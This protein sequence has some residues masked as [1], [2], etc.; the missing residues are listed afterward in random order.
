MSVSDVPELF[1]NAPPVRLQRKLGLID[2]RTRSIGKRALI[3]VLVGWLPLNL[4][5]LL[6]AYSGSQGVIS[7]LWWEIGVHA[8]YLVAAPLLVFAENACAPRLN[9]II[10][11]FA[12]SGIVQERDRHRFTEA[13]A[14]TRA[15]V[16]SVA[17]EIVVIACAYVVTASALYA[18]DYGQIPLWYK[19]DGG[20]AV[21]S[22]AGWWHSLVSLPLLLALIFGWIWRLVLWSRLL[23]L[24]ARLKLRLVASHPDHAAGLGFVGQSLEAFSVVGLAM[25]TI[26]A[27]RSA[28]IVLTTGSV[29]TPNLFANIGILIA[30]LVLFAAPLLI[31][32]PLLLRTWQRGTLDYGALAE[33][34]GIAFERKWIT[35]AEIK[36]SALQ[37]P[38]FSATTDLY[39]IA[40]NVT[41]MRLIPVDSKDLIALCTAMLIPFVPVVLLAVPADTIIE[42]LKKLLL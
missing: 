10:H 41:A 13:I 38:D 8:R 31:F 25:T 27:G 15:L 18:H 40:A 1:E 9:R 37:Q 33:H 39:S 19:S 30:L 26:A 5:A 29:P 24:I 3:I 7:S 32:T 16:D 42:T 2:A 12:D 4:L 34:V 11:E 23:W 14:S 22:P 20:A 21:F 35:K 6:Q 17:A 36:E 28:N